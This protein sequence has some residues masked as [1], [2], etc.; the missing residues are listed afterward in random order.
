MIV[1]HERTRLDL[2]WILQPA[3]DIRILTVQRAPGE[4]LPACE[5]SEVRAAGAL[6]I[7]S[8][9][10]VASDAAD[11]STAADRPEGLGALHGKRSIRRR[12]RLLLLIA[13]PLG[14]VLRRFGHNV[15]P[16]EGVRPG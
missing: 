12:Q 3:N 7:R 4:A 2:I 8:S 6:R 16:H 15:E 5:V 9:D 11:P 14:V 13:D 10:G 1:G